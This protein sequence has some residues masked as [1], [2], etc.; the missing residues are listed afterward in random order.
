[1][2]RIISAVLALCAPAV[3][4]GQVMT[5]QS[6]A[7]KASQLRTLV[8]GYVSS[9]DFAEFRTNINLT[10]TV[11]TSTITV[12]SADSVCDAVT[13]GVNAASQSS[14]TTA[15]LVVKFGSFFAA[16]DGT[17]GYAVDPIYILDDHYHLVTVMGGTG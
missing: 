15:L 8:V 3:L 12:V 1:M 9:S 5:C 16:C 4:V 2:K 14:R 6:S 11:D 10:S 17:E 7:T 13:R